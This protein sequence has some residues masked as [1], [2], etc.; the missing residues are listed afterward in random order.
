MSFELSQIFI[1]EY[2]PEAAE[3]CNQNGDCYITEIEAAADGSRR[4]QIVAIPD[5]TPEELAKQERMNKE[6]EAEAARVPDLEAAV[7]ELGVTFASD[8]EESDA[9]ALDLAAYAAELEQRIAK[10]EEKNG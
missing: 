9:A 8:K 10:L 5:P 2:P 4:F 6:A 1:G 3:W 7:A